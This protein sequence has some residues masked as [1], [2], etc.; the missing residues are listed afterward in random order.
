MQNA[1]IAKSI[2]VSIAAQT[3]E[4]FENSKKIFDFEC[5]TGDKAHPTDRGF[6]HILRRPADYHYRSH[7]YNAQMN[8]PLFFTPDGKAFHQYH[9]PIPL[10]FVR[11][12]RNNVTDW[13]GSHGC[14]RLS[15]ENARSLYNWASVGVLVQI[16]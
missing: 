4:V 12:A 5:V 13:V 8:Y 16:Q 9:G 14:V 3:V 6:F 11:M 7:K 10:S 2:R 1:R 15:E